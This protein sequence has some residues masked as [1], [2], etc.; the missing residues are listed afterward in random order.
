MIMLDGLEN[1]GDV[2]GDQERDTLEFITNYFGD[3][4]PLADERILCRTLLSC[5]KSIDAALRKGREISRLITSFNETLE[6]LKD[7]APV[8][9][10][11]DTEV[12]DL[13]RQAAA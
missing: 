9:S 7:A 2:V 10:D 3:R 8:I 13:L 4:Q 1:V 11:M 12:A 6:S 5:A